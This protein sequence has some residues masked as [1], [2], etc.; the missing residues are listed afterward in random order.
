MR[1]LGMLA[2]GAL[3]CWGMTHEITKC[4]NRAA[5]LILNRLGE[6]QEKLEGIEH[7]LER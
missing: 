7:A 5:A 6:M 4:I 3:F 2:V 1:D